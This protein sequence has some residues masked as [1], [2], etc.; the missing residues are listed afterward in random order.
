[1]KR[2]GSSNVYRLTR[3]LRGLGRNVA[4]KNRHSIARHVMRDGRMRRKVLEILKKD[5]Q[6]ELECMCSVQQAS[7]LRV[8]S[9][10]LLREF[11][12]AKLEEELITKAPNLHTIL[13]GA[14]Y[15][16]RP[17]SKVRRRSQ[18]R[19]RVN[20]SA[21]LGMSAAILCRY[22]SQ[23]MNQFQ[24]FLSLLLYK[25]GANKQVSMHGC[26]CIHALRFKY[27]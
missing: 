25:G 1:M 18:R 27:C 19:K 26:T 9:P 5:I 12:W 14:L 11:S 23:S 3:S 13:D 8:A 7:T 20:R 22:R 4:R 17:P 15:I 6:K 16:H 24:R 2:K 21:I 10:A